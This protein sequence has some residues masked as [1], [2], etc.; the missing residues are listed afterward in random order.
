MNKLAGV[1]SVE[2]RKTLKKA[3]SDCPASC[4]RNLSVKI[5]KP[6]TKDE[7]EDLKWHLYYDTVQIYILNRRWHLYIQGNCQY[8]ND[9]NLCGIYEDRPPKCRNHNPPDC[10]RFGEFYDIMFSTPDELER[11]LN[12]NKKK[13]GAY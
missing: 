8:L 6:R 13:R 1:K 11:H 5:L 9:M 12:D 7:I 4:C 3:C 10:E 2:K